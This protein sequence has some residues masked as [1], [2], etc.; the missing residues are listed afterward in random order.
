MSYYDDF[1]LLIKSNDNAGFLGLWEEY[2]IGGGSDGEELLKILKLLLVSDMKDVFDAYAETIIPLWRDIE[3]APLAYEVLKLILDLEATNSD[4]LAQV[5]YNVLKERYGDHKLF[6]EKIRLVGLRNKEHFQGAIRNYE[7]LSHLDTGAFVYHTAGW[8][9]GEV[10]EYSLVREEL[11]FEF[12][13][14]LGRKELTFD[15]AFKNLEPLPKKHF[16]SCRFGNPEALE[17]EAKKDAVKVV[18]MLLKDLGDKT[19]AEIKEEMY[20]LVIPAADWS[21]WWQGARAKVKKDTM[22]E[23]PISM[24]YPFRLRSDEVS[25]EERF[26]KELGKTKNIDQG[27]RAIYYFVRHFPEMVEEPNLATFLKQHIV[28]FLSEEK[29]SSAQQFQLRILFHDLFEKE[30]PPDGIALDAFVCALSSPD[31]TTRE[32]EITALRKRALECTKE[33]RP[34]RKEIFLEQFFIRQPSS[35]RDYLLKELNVPETKSQLEAK[36]IDLLSN[37]ALYPEAFVWYFQKVMAKM[38][39]PFSDPAGQC[40]F[41]EAFLILYHTIESLPEH[42]D[43]VKKMF[44][45][46]IGNRYAIL[47]EIVAE[48]GLEYAKEILLLVS[49]CRTLSDHN[50][51]IVQ[52]I[53]YAQHSELKNDGEKEE[54]REPVWT[55]QEGYDKVQEKIK[56]L[57]TVELVKNAKE[58]EEARSHGD[59]RENAEYKCALEKRTQLQG[60]MKMLS[61]QLHNA[62]I[63]TRQDVSD[64]EV[65]VGT[66]VEV[67][68]S[69]GKTTSYTLLGPWDASPEDNVLSFQSR[70]AEAMLNAKK[71]DTFEYQGKTLKI[72]S[73]HNYFDTLA[74]NSK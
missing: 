10:M 19:A 74:T 37:S 53:I 60:E 4:E 54:K 69:Q 44:N 55:T 64:R 67:E 35:L 59:L 39:I 29:I 56:E 73:I 11:F 22:I 32:I 7:L 40:Q 72:A 46:L 68:D 63:L 71:D 13:G 34:D 23:S 14:V 27:L 18:R 16:L 61:D 8:G 15:N 20:E 50:A 42:R 30:P 36:L 21:K 17:A 1:D 25:H 2:C 48:C 62:R 12:E 43:L 5:A 3:D 58:I 57:G 49:K 6:N 41:F 24:K 66:V 45:L 31:E 52:S 9:T 51:K 47:R 26:R 70:F 65:C 38:H 28:T 33:W